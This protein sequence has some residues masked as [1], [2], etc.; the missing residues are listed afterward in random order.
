MRGAARRAPAVGARRRRHRYLSPPRLSRVL[1]HGHIS[2][3]SRARS[4]ALPS[5]LPSTFAFACA[6]ADVDCLFLCSIWNAHPVVSNILARRCPYSLAG[7]IA[8]SIPA[9]VSTD[10]SGQGR[11][12]G[13]RCVP[14][15][16]E[17][18]SHQHPLGTPSAHPW[19]WLG[20][21]RQIQT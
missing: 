13:A 17:P 18:S 3:S 4:P 5:C 19:R 1:S 11:E 12:G 10:D 7:H 21:K 15:I 14:N 9:I 20:S 6:A 2:R 8:S 16:S